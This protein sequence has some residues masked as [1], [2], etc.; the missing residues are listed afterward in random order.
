MIGYN[1]NM[2][3]LSGGVTNSI[4]IGNAIDVTTSNTIQLGNSS[5]TDLKTFGKITSGTI[6]YPNTHNSTAGQ[7]LTTNAAGVASW[8]TPSTTA[9]AYSGTLPIANG[10]TGLTTTPANGQIDIGNGTGFTRATLTAGTAIT[11]TNTA[12]AITISAAVRPTTDQFTA[13][14]A[15]TSFTVT[16]TPLNAK[17]WM[18]INGVRTNNSA[19]SIS[20]TTIT[21]TPA[22]NNSYTLVVGDRI[23]FDYAY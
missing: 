6:T 16:Q 20:G 5:V 1:A 10:G 12:G 17:V 9:T 7:I 14:A 22:S 13:T 4:A 11:I 21:Y 3:G 8:A 19:Y 2:S 15:Q 23:Q 18:F